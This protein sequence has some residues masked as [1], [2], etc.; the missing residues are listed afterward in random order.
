MG[1][2]NPSEFPKEIQ[3]LILKRQ[4][5]AGNPPDITLF[6][7]NTI[8]SSV[9][10][11]FTWDKTKEGSNFWYNILMDNNFEVFYKKYPQSKEH[12]IEI[13]LI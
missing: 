4:V 13:S 2:L 1:R 5:E 11:G 7:E 12:T 8:I 3:E 6:D 9:N 10:G